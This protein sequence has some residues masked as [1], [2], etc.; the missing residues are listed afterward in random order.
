M[1]GCPAA[2]EMVKPCLIH[3]HLDLFDPG[4]CGGRRRNGL[5][6]GRGF[7]ARMNFGLA[8]SSSC[9]KKASI[10]RLNLLTIVFAPPAAPPPAAAPGF[11][12]VM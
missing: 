6:F 11:C 4:A 7:I 8:P 12:R 2:N 1:L 10:S 3:L 9:L 5:T